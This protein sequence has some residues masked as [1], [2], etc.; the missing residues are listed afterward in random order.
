MIC[1][2]IMQCH[3]TQITLKYPRNIWNV[4]ITF[5]LTSSAHLS[6]CSFTTGMS[7]EEIHAWNARITGSI[8]FIVVLRTIYHDY[9]NRK[10]WKSDP[11]NLPIQTNMK[12]YYISTF[13][14]VLITIIVFI[15][16]KINPIC[17]YTYGFVAPSVLWP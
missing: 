17:K 9:N 16:R 4:P 14:A 13:I 6:V 11:N 5:K 15:L 12:F 1:L 3:H 7:V 10:K 8:A 2:I